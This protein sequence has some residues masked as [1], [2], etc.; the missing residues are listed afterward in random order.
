MQGTRV[1]SLA[2]EL[3]FHMLCSAVEGN[4]EGKERKERKERKK[5]GRKS[6]TDSVSLKTGT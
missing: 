1:E 2:R 3:R 5:D 6:P 4:K